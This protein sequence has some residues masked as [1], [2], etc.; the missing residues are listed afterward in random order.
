MPLKKKKPQQGQFWPS[1]AKPDRAFIA[2]E[3][4]NLDEKELRKLAAYELAR[5]AARR[6]QCCPVTSMS[7]RQMFP[8]HFPG[9]AYLSIPKSVRQNAD[10]EGNSD[11]F[12]SKWR[13]LHFSIRYG[14]SDTVLQQATDPSDLI[15]NLIEEADTLNSP[16]GKTIQLGLRQ[17]HRMLFASSRAPEPDEMDRSMVYPGLEI[18]L[19]FADDVLVEEFRKL[20]DLA[21]S[22]RDSKYPATYRFPNLKIDA[23]LGKLAATRLWDHHGTVHEAI[24]VLV[25][26]NVCGPYSTLEAPWSKARA[27]ILELCQAGGRLPVHPRPKQGSKKP[28]PGAKKP[29]P[30]PKKADS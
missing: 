4:L 5:E 11:L 30:G 9:D 12:R 22:G 10:W 3:S 13:G 29:K 7:L 6:G 18:N 19:D 27:Q 15:K 21:R 16:A 14:S 2:P 25:E 8:D 26:E 24:D 28:R 17:L 23:L 1:L 20:L